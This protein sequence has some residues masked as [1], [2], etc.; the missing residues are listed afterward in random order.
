MSERDVDTV[1]KQQNEEKFGAIG[2]EQ[3]K[4]RVLGSSAETLQHANGPQNAPKMA[5]KS[6]KLCLLRKL[7]VYYVNTVYYVNSTLYLD[8][9]SPKRTP[10]GDEDRPAPERCR[11]SSSR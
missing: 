7:V 5:R 4:L 3:V 6:Q 2:E 8:L 10:Q 1:S 9:P 11:L